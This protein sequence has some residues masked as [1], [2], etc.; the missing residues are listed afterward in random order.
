VCRQKA[1]PYQTPAAP[2]W[3]ADVRSAFFGSFHEMLCVPACHYISEI[4]TL[5]VANADD[6]H[7]IIDQEAGS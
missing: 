5:G 3:W 1:S 7:G 4:G 2:W 6:D